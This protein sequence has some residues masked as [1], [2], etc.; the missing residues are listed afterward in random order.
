MARLRDAKGSRARWGMLPWFVASTFVVFGLMAAWSVSMPLYS[1]PDEPSQVIHAAALVRGQLIGTPDAGYQ[2]PSST[3]TVPGTFGNGAE[4]MLCYLWHPT[5]PASCAAHVRLSAH[6]GP[7]LDLLRSLSAAVLR[8]RRTADAG[9]RLHIRRD[10]DAT[11]GRLA[12]LDPHRPGPH[13]DSRLVSIAHPPD[14][15]SLRADA[16]CHLHGSD[17]QPQRSG[18]RSG[19]LPL[20]RRIDSGVGARRRSAAGVDRGARGLGLRADIDSGT[21]T[22]LDDPGAG[23]GRAPRRA[24]GRVAASANSPGRAVGGGGALRPVVCSP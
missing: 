10:L 13:V 15:L 16:G 4:L 5:V 11:P 8:H 21:L 24:S 20:V 6:P 18:D 9:D 23:C 12:V 17:G 22:T 1:G 7:V 19:D 14:G 2:S 3:V